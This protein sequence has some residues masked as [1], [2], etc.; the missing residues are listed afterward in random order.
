MA[1]RFVFN[2]EKKEAKTLRRE[3][4]QPG[5]IQR[6]VDG[7]F[8]INK[9]FPRIFQGIMDTLQSVF[10]DLWDIQF[11]WEYV[12]RGFHTSRFY[13]IIRFPEFIIKNS[14]NLQTK[15]QDLFVRIPIEIEANRL[16]FERIQG[17]RTSFTNA[18]NGTYVHSHI[19]STSPC[20]Y[21]D[22]CTGSGE[23]NNLQAMLNGMSNRDFDFDL[24]ALFLMHLN[25]FVSWES[26]EGTPYKYISALLES[27]DEAKPIR[28]AHLRRYHTGIVNNIKR[29][30][31]KPHLDKIK[32]RVNNGRYEIVDNMQLESALINS[33]NGVSNVSSLDAVLCM[34]NNRGV[35]IKQRALVNQSSTNSSR[36]LIFRGEKIPYRITDDFEPLHD[37]E[38]YVNPSIKNYFKKQLENAANSKAITKNYL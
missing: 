15:I 31:N 19:H 36:Y 2:A 16:N 37:P 26:L 18:E 17:T 13:I 11:E 34:K 33:M 29:P 1:R 38:L 23:I 32:W 14:R 30:T 35:Y 21:D 8:I 10:P 24:F 28:K 4:L 6:K 7:N 20:S 5:Y 3:Y 12:S 27:T 25:T 9:D 22:F